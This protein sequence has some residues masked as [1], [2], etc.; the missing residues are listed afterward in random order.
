MQSVILSGTDVIHMGNPYHRSG[1]GR[2]PMLNVSATKRQ[3]LKRLSPPGSE[4]SATVAD[5]GSIR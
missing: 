1:S 3:N 2:G 5:R 4:P